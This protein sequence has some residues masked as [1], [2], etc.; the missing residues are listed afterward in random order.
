M[1]LKNALPSVILLIAILCCKII[2]A[3]NCNNVDF[4]SNNFSN[5]TGYTG[6]CCPIV[7]NTNGIVNGQHTI[8][9]GAGFDP[10]IPQI[11]VV[12]PFGGS[13]SVR[14]GNSNTG[15]G[16]ERLV[17]NFQVTAANPN[18]TYQYAVILEDP[19]HIDADQPRFQVTVKNSSNQTIPC[20][21]YDVVAKG[22]IP[23]FQ[24]TNG[25]VWKDWSLV[26]VDLSGYIG[27]T[28]K[29]EF[30]TGDCNQ[31][32][33]YGYAYIDASCNPLAIASNY[34]PGD[35]AATLTAPAGF[36]SYLWS[37]GATT[38]SI[39][40]NNPI[41]GDTISVRATPYQGANCATTLKYVFQLYPPITA[42]YTVNTSCGNNNVQFTDSSYLNTNNAQITGWDWYVNN[43]LVD[44]QQNLSYSFPGPG[45]YNIT[46]ISKS[47]TG[48]PDTISKQVLIPQGIDPNTSVPST[49]LYNG[50]GVSCEEKNDGIVAVTATY[51]SP[52][53]TFQWSTNPVSTNDSVF[54]LAA[55]DYF[56]TVTDSL[57]CFA[58]EK[59][60]VV[61]PPKV[62]IQPV[63][64][65]IQCF[66]YT[67]GYI[68]L[69]PSGS[70]QA[71]SYSWSRNNALNSPDADNLGIGTYTVTITYGNNCA[72]DT[73][74]TISGPTVPY[75]I[76][77][78]HT[79][80]ICFGA[81]TGS[82]SVDNV[83]GNTP[84]YAYTWN[85]TP[86]QTTPQITGLCAGVY[87]CLIV[88]SNHCKDSVSYTITEP[89]A[90]TTSVSVINIA[91]G[92]PTTGTATITASGGTAPYTYSWSN[93]DPTA[94][95][96]GLAAGTYYCTVYDA[97]QC[98]ATD[99]GTITSPA[100]VSVSSAKQ[101]VRCFGGNSGKI[102]TTT[103][104]GTNNYNYAWNTTPVKTTANLTNIIAGTYT[105]TVTDA[106]GCKDTATEII[107][108][109]ALLTSSILNSTNNPCFANK[110]GG[111]TVDAQGGVTP[112]S[113]LWS[114]TPAQ[115]TQTATNLRAGNY[116]VIITDDSL[117][118]SV[119][120]ITIT[121]P[122][123]L[124]ISLT[125]TDVDCFG[126]S[127]G[128]ADATAAG[129]TTP[130]SYL[131]SNGPATSANPNIPAGTYT[132]TITDANNC[133]AS[134]SITITEPALLTISATGQ[135]INCFGNNSGKIW[136]TT[137]GGTTAYTYAWS[138]N[139]PPQ[140]NLV[141]LFAN[142][143]TVTVTDAHN[144]TAT[145]TQILTEPT[146][147]GSSITDTLHNV[148]FGESKGTATVTGT[149]GAIPYKYLWNISPQHT[150]DKATSLAAGNYTVTV[151]DDSLCTTTSAVTITQ[152]SQLTITPAIINSSC[153]DSTQGSIVLAASGA[154]PVYAY[155]WS[156]G[157]AGTETAAHLMAGNYAVT[158][159][160]ANNCSQNRS[161]VIN[162]PSKLNLT[163]K[164]TDAL[165]TG[166]ADGII[167]S[168]TTGGTAAYQYDL[169]QN[170]NTLTSNPT[171][172][173]AGL[174]QGSYTIQSTD[175]NGCIITTNAVVNEPT[176]LQ[177]QSMVTDSV[178]CFGYS[179]GSILI[180]ATGG[181]PYYTYEL[182]TFETNSSGSFTG[183]AAGNYQVIIT[184]QHACSIT[185]HIGIFQPD[186][187]LLSANPDLL[188]LTLGQGATIQLTS[189]YAPDAI[190]S[191]L[192][193]QGLDCYTC[194]KVNVMVYNDIE[195]TVH[196]TTHPHDLDCE[197]EITVPVTII[198][199]YDVYIPNLFTPNG[200]GRNDFFEFYGNKA[201]IKKANIM[202]FNRIGEKVYDSDSID[203]K[204]DG[205]HLG[206]I[207]EPGV[208]VYVMKLVF[209]DDH[210][211]NDFKGSVT[212]L[213]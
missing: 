135:N 162:Q 209:M 114:S 53:Y 3:Q 170:G 154:T 59:T 76:T 183:L 192:P 109:P 131:W 176:P 73:S 155:T 11:S 143:Y 26:A 201:A 81:C 127:T 150:S 116:S 105:V 125:K 40:V 90:I 36:Q 173:F 158:V 161:Y 182:V 208:Y 87:Q 97:N 62:A 22:N 51:G 79:D 132:C 144:C 37:T 180:T 6:S 146:G 185:E 123:L 167:L 13:Y 179:D 106:N 67:D 142:T 64:K 54:N 205:S 145:A 99:S 14:L 12:S 66:G 139:A 95:T 202:I 18:F 69:N 120:S 72:W 43:I 98:S 107:T 113:Y 45:N 134:A 91:C 52:P 149:G 9:T 80:N 196:I 28:V 50:Y 169:Q 206:N 136:T 190:Y 44:S 21:F 160:D 210:V 30:Q 189:N 7:A 101:D 212:I 148:C 83:S 152:P 172:L 111:A 46:L 153:F 186:S 55:G 104:G 71:S 128:S 8:M 4:E 198:P 1:T 207:Q 159:T 24:T 211:K 78:S 57:G 184:D 48:C 137:N 17:Y 31:G 194:D 188:Y 74:F 193:T 92:G 47:A 181:I 58:V 63:I 75:N 156:P 38:Q 147:L 195:Y 130:Y 23:G 41:P 85:T 129:G 5:W 133:T 89:A 138:N 117:C 16:A 42:N 34:C 61:P 88:D 94:T 213:K 115:N 70:V 163:A 82:A 164:I 20:G 100:L 110:L 39:V 96:T 2:N 19:G 178:N 86:A 157:G 124:T 126:N 141:G 165:C 77:A 103:T 166:S 200:D 112:Y 33:H 118:T 32:G 10:I 108:E 25:I 29:I 35:P 174:L 27:Q 102:V 151:T 65:N 84:P 199:N 49:Q 60:S 187:I 171:G 140:A 168:G 175:K 191:W 15:N 68:H 93:G 56:V 197:S 119:S 177:V 204:W 203:F 121:E 122:A